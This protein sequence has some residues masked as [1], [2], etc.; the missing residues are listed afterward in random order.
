[1]F[2]HWRGLLEFE[3]LSGQQSVFCHWR[4]L[5][6]L[7]VLSGQQSVFCHWRGL[8]ELEVLSGQHSSALSLT[9]F[10]RTRGIIRPTSVFCHWRGLL[11][12][13]VL[14]GQQSIVLSLTWFIGTGGIIRPT[15]KCSFTDVVYWNSGY[16]PA[17]SQVFS[18]W[19]GL[20]ELEVLSGQQSSVLSLTWFIWTRGIIWPTVKCSVTDVVY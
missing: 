16:Y 4:G 9:W 3:V 7:E 18:H 17:N 13:E 15:V 14:S 2:C 1:M 12:L 8:L 11:E 10:I 5:L 19:R 6:A 20:L